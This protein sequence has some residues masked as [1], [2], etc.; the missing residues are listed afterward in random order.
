MNAK[1]L[2]GKAILQELIKI[3]T[4]YKT[5]NGKSS[6]RLEHGQKVSDSAINTPIGIIRCSLKFT[7]QTVGGDRGTHTK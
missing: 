4:I 3:E 6:K 7:F 1:K 2:L 5:N